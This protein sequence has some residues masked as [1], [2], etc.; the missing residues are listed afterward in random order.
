[1]LIITDFI[2]FNQDA[3]DI[4][5][6]LPLKIVVYEAPKRA[7]RHEPNLVTQSV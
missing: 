3:R 5:Y 6:I 1:M 4:M 2:E 7:H